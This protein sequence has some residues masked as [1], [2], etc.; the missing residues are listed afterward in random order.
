MKRAARY[1]SFIEHARC[2][3]RIPFESGFFI[4]FK[5]Y[6]GYPFRALLLYLAGFAQYLFK[7]INEQI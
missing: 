7:N 1:V 2:C 5:L 3:R 6:P 4:A